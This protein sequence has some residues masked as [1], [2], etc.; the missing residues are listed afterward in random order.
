M[1]FR[2][3]RFRRPCR[4]AGDRVI[5]GEVP[6]ARDVVTH[7]DGDVL[8]HA[9]CDVLLDAQWTSQMTCP[10]NLRRRVAAERR[11]N[12]FNVVRRYMVHEV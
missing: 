3:G 9:L 4:Q 12:R 7:S 8:I 1:E 10:R 5:I 11:T 6:Y 2:I